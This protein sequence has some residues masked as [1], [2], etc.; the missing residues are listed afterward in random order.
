MMVH[1]LDALK[2]GT[3]I[4]EYGRLTFVMVARY[5]ES[6]EEMIKLLAKQPGFDQTKARALVLQVKQR[7][8]NP[9][10][11]ERILQWQSKQDFPI[12]PSPDDPKSCNVY[13]ELKFPDEV[14]N[15]INE[16]YEERA[17][18]EDKK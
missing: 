13:T 18:A 8:Y 4:G 11:R 17:E 16:F 3:D 9:P 15:N 14:Y 5:F 2:A 1:L 10:K 7:G 12:C 6:D